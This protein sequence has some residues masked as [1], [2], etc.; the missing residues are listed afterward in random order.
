MI[1]LNII[2]LSFDCQFLELIEINNNN[3]IDSELDSR[4]VSLH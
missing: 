1:V 4:E 3:N 2:Y